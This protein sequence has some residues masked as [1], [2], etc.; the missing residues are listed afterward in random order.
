MAAITEGNVRPVLVESAKRGKASADMARGQAVVIDAAAAADPRYDANYKAAI[1][2][3]F[4][5]GVTL[6]ACKAGGLVEI[7]ILGEFDGYTGLTP[8]APLSVAAGKID[9][10]A[11]TAGREQIYALSATRIA[12]RL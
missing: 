10:T 11:P 1:A 8:G 9:A 6:K 4:I 2:E 3:P 12:V 5:H 7:M